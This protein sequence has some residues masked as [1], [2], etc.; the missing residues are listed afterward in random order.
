MK[1]SYAAFAV[2][3]Y[4][5]QASAQVEVQQGK[6]IADVA[7]VR[8]QHC[9]AMSAIRTATDSPMLYRS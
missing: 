1:D 2:T 3:N 6:N 7:K 8:S 9:Y 5:E 4:W